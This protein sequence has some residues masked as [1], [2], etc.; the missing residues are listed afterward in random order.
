[1]DSYVSRFMTFG[2]IRNQNLGFIPKV[3]PAAP[4]LN[5]VSVSHH[6]VIEGER[7]VCF[8]IIPDF[9][10]VPPLSLLSAT[11]KRR[12]VVTPFSSRFV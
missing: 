7:P 8:E 10:S 2:Y 5:I 4:I 1:M 6:I 9:C 11:Y 3:C 12:I